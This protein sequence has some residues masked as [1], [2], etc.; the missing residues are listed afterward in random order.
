MSELSRRIEA[1]AKKW[2]E[3]ALARYADLEHKKVRVHSSGILAIDIA[4]RC[5][6]YPIGAITEAFGPEGGGKTTIA[7]WF[8]ASVQNSGGTVAYINP[9]QKG[10]P[11]YIR[12]M[13]ESYGGCADDL[14]VSMPDSGEQALDIVETL[15]DVADAIVLDSV[16]DLVSHIELDADDIRDHHV[17][18]QARMMTKFLKRAKPKLGLSK[19]ALLFTNQVRANIGGY[20]SSETTPGGHALRHACM[21]RLRVSQ[22]GAAI[23]DRGQ[24]VG[25][26][27]KA[28]VRKN[29]AGA[30]NSIA[31]FNIIWG[32]GIDQYK[33]TFE[34]AKGLEVFRRAGSVY[35]YVWDENLGEES[36]LR[37]EEAVK[38]ALRTDPRLMERVRADVARVLAGEKDDEQT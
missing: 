19:S 34:A 3:D 22:A 6:G 8:L 20:G 21:I 9:E 24:E 37:G 32:Q 31:E 18:I 25:I 5:G 7:L 30:P 29:Q 12:A 15:I 38:D 36:S 11:S 16:A 4:T 33:D 26:P 27:C 13:F 14:L 28:K 10:D 17:G 35:Y 23:R 1:I 2:G